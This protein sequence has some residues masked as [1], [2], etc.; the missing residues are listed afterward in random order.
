MSSMIGAV[1]SQQ[2][3]QLRGRRHRRDSTDCFAA[4]RQDMQHV[5]QH[6]DFCISKLIEAEIIP[7]LLVAHATEGVGPHGAAHD[8]PIILIPGIDAIT[9]AEVEAFAPLTLSVEAAELLDQVET[10]LDRGVS[11]ETLLVDLL[12]PT[13][14]LLG[15]YWEEDR[16]DFVEVTMGLWRL[17]EIVHEISARIPSAW[18]SGLGGKRILIASLPGDQHS[19]GALLLDE[20]FSR[21][22][23]TTNRPGEVSLTELLARASEEWFDIVGLTIGTDSHIGALPSVIASLRNVSRNPQLCI[24]VGGPTFVLHPELAMEVG[25][26]G[27][28]PN[29]SLAVKLAEDL[30]AALEREATY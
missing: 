26:D 29:A 14:R 12:A 17:Q 13:A 5:V 11:V 2:S 6:H 20:I 15:Q 30:I 18:Q 7:R 25:A 24:M 8:E 21:N 19:F 28:A 10:M 22:G 23:W 16:C 9:S 1:R 27:T 3:P 4:F